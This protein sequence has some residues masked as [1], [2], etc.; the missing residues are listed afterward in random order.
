MNIIFVPEMNFIFQNVSNFHV[1]HCSGGKMLRAKIKQ[2]CPPFPSF[3]YLRKEKRQER[4]FFFFLVEDSM[5]P[6]KGP[7]AGELFKKKKKSSAPSGPC[8][9]RAPGKGH[10]ASQ[11]LFGGPGSLVSHHLTP[12]SCS[13]IKLNK[14]CDCHGNLSNTFK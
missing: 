9:S 8:V 7:K 12:C 14:R 2:H 1:Y 4:N 11:P 13:L 6:P 5:T 3:K 10:P